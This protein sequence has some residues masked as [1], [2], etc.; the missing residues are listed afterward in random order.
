MDGDGGVVLPTLAMA[1]PIIPQG[2]GVVGH[3]MYPRH[4]HH[5]RNQQ[6]GHD[7]EVWLG[8]NRTLAVCRSSVPFEE[9]DP[10]NNAKYIGLNQPHFPPLFRLSAK[11]EQKP[12]RQA[13]PQTLRS[14]HTTARRELDKWTRM[15][16]PW[17]S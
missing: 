13:Y 3:Q 11:I 2:T 12:R 7:V 6:K 15:F 17:R 10:T 8:V 1:K 14:P 4:P 16:W 9:K 5:Q